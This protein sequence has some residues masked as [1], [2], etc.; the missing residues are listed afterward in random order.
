MRYVIFPLL[1]SLLLAFMF[2]PGLRP[3][4][5]ASTGTRPRIGTSLIRRI[6]EGFNS[7]CLHGIGWA[8]LGILLTLLFPNRFIVRFSSGNVTEAHGVNG[9]HER[10]VV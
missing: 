9:Q 3:R 4:L 10:D 8:V 2:L 5:N 1:P 7:S 6:T